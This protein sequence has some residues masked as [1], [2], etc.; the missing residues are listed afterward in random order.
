M[1]DLTRVK[2]FLT[3]RAARAAIQR[4][5]N[6]IGKMLNL[7]IDSKKKTIHAEIHLKGEEAPVTVRVGRYELI[8]ESGKTFLQLDAVDASR[9]WMQLLFQQL[10]REKRI[11]VPALLKAAL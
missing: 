7:A 2:D 1:I 10:T 6:P 8:E 4:R 3:G 5:F 11:E 9:E